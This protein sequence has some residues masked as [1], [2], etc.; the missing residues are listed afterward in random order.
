MSRKHRSQNW[1]REER[2]KC[3]LSH[4]AF[5][6]HSESA[7]TSEAMTRLIR[8]LTGLPGQLDPGDMCWLHRGTFS[9]HAEQ[10][11][12]QGVR[13]QTRRPPITGRQL[14]GAWSAVG[15]LCH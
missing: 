8:N 13:R 12:R 2:A 3:Q 11:G 5:S 7:F 15:P 10:I 9:K 6:L 1:R 4:D 14:V